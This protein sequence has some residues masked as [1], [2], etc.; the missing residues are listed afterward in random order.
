M[1]IQAAGRVRFATRPREVVT[2]QCSEMPGVRLTREFRSLREARDFFG[3]ATG[4]EF[5][6]LRQQIEAER[7]RAEGL[8]VGAIAQRLGV[9][10]RTV[11]YRLSA[12]R[13]RIK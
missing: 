4:S 3:L 12:A 7:Q 8:T 13:G 6:R 9:S 1:V 10:V 11:R 2:F 5:D